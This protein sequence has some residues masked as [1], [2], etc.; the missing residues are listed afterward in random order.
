LLVKSFKNEEKELSF[1]IC[2]INK[3]E[4]FPQN[5]DDKGCSCLV[6]QMD[7]LNV[8][9]YKKFTSCIGNESSGM[10]PPRESHINTC[11]GYTAKAIQWLPIPD[12]L[13]KLTTKKDGKV[14]ISTFFSS[15]IA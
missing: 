1:D 9:R 3:T 11:I 5:K 10:I 2:L 7:R 12:R 14:L 13:S 15:S 6:M 4:Y 8:S